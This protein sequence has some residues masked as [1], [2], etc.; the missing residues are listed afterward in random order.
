MKLRTIVTLAL[1]AAARPPAA[2]QKVDTAARA[3][4]VKAQQAQAA[5]PSYRVVQR[6][7]RGATGELIS[8]ELIY[9]APD[10]YHMRDLDGILEAQVIRIGAEGWM[11]TKGYPWG[12]ELV[13]SVR[14][15]Q[16][17]RGPY[18]LGSAGFTLVDAK[19]LGAEEQ[20]RGMTKTYEYTVR[21]DNETLRVK[22]WVLDATGLPIRYEGEHR[23]RTDTDGVRWDIAYD[24]PLK[25][26]RP[27]K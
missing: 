6:T 8:A 24:E 10:R 9:V 23:M 18:A 11:R 20:P 13:L 4:I 5:K 2:A 14:G 16:W 1:V 27:V 22:M 12:T 19:A 17:F 25:V 26:D 7:K 15:L 3:A 21:D